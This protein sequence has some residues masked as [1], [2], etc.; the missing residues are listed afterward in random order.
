ML[1]DYL[2][3]STGHSGNNIFVDSFISFH[4]FE[5][6]SS[7]GNSPIANWELKQNKIRI[8]RMQFEVKY[9]TFK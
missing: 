3:T 6:L 4:A 8:A 9:E 5:R 2:R 1:A 7:F